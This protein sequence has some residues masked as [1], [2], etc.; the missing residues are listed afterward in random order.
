MP[1]ETEMILEQL[2]EFNT[3]MKCLQTEFSDFKTEGRTGLTKTVVH[4]N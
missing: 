1:T 3:N 2:K 4:F